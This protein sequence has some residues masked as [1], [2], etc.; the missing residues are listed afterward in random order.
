LRLGFG[1]IEWISLVLL[2]KSTVSTGGFDELRFEALYILLKF[3]FRTHAEC[4][5]FFV[6]WLLTGIQ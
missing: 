4:D 6:F 3:L 5:S 1:A 2:N